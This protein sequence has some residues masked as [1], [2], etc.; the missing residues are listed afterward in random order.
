MQRAAH[1]AA[2]EKPAAGACEQYPQ[3]GAL[4]PIPVFRVLREEADLPCGV[5]GPVGFS[6]FRRRAVI[7]CGDSIIGSSVERLN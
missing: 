6:E 2:L 3:S 4:E 1:P 7:W 5:R